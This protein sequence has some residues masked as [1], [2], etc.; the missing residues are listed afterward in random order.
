MD[1]LN[2]MAKEKKVD[3]TLQTTKYFSYKHGTCNL[4]FSL[5]VDSKSE[6]LIFKKI[7]EQ[8]IVD[9]QEEIDK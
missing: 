2:N 8:A 3:I 9:V 6:L 5:R 4:S 7:L 1:Y